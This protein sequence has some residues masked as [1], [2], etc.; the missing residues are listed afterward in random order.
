[1]MGCWAC[2]IRLGKAAKSP[3]SQAKYRANG[4]MAFGLCA[5]DLRSQFYARYQLMCGVSVV[6][7][8]SNFQN[9]KNHT[10]SVSPKPSFVSVRLSVCPL[11]KKGRSSWLYVLYIPEQRKRYEWKQWNNSTKKLRT[12]LYEFFIFPLF[13]FIYLFLLCFFP[14]LV[15]LWGNLWRTIRWDCCLWSRAGGLN[16]WERVVR[17]FKNGRG[18]W[19]GETLGKKVVRS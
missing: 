6:C 5:S 10:Q 16:P 14:C 1:M 19:W 11:R 12:V 9:D 4:G 18:K 2:W 8:W 13:Y 17:Y 15:I 3:P 7:C